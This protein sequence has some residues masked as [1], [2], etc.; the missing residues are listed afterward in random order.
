MAPLEDLEDVVMVTTSEAI[1]LETHTIGSLVET[2]RRAWRDKRRGRPERIRYTRGEDVVIERRTRAVD[3]ADGF[4]TPYQAVRTL[5]DIH[6]KPVGGEDPLRVFCSALREVG[7][8]GF[9]ERTIVCASVADLEKWLGVG[10]LGQVFKVRAYEDPSVPSAI[11]CF[12]CGSAE[13][14][15]LTDL[16]FSIGIQREE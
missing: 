13:G 4:L 6:L 15:M 2:I 11:R 12:M 16:D 7:S 8:R 14:N 9:S 10:E 5:T 1:P 3:V